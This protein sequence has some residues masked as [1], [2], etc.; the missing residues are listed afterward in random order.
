MNF[1]SMTTSQKWG[2]A[3][4]LAGV[5][6]SHE[7]CQNKGG[8]SLA[9]TP[10]IAA[11]IS[12]SAPGVLRTETP[13]QATATGINV[14]P[15]YFCT[16]PGNA[17][18]PC[19]S[20][21]ICSP[22]SPGT[23][24]TVDNVLVDTGSF[25]LRLF[26]S[27]ISIGLTQLQDGTGRDIAQCAL[28]G[29]GSTWGPV[30]QALVKLGG[31]A[32]SSIPIQVINSSYAT[33][34]TLCSSS[35]PATSPAESGFNGILGIGPFGHDCGT[36][37]G[38]PTYY[39]C[40]GAGTCTSTAPPVLS[41]QVINPVYAQSQDNNGVIVALPGVGLPGATS[42][43]GALIMG[44][45][46]QANNSATGVTA[47]AMNSYMN[48]TTQFNGTSL[49]ESFIDSGTNAFAFPAVPGMNDCGA[50]P[51]WFCP[52][53]PACYTTTLISSTGTTTGISNFRVD[54][55][56][57]IFS[58]GVTIVPTV[59]FGVPSGMSNSFD[60][61]LPFFFG[62]A[63]YVGFKG[64]TATGISITGPYWAY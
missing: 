27:V 30:Q 34:P 9:A 62:R 45:G 31:E 55:A 40:N 54:N 60:W 11:S 44:I 33:M 20:V 4:I 25:G 50:N 8:S 23:C 32:A 38:N 6:F 12:C 56:D 26:S 21:T 63:V 58:Q 57:G 15:I 42:L 28:F 29:I 52:N 61:G 2:L 14:T 53:T 49:T 16:A 1:S 22:T 39:G 36:S 46:T 35:G 17:N 47:Y 37:C 64:R 13:P 7:A 48:F 19:V 3:F 18:I 59:A 51:G 41:K 10:T 43:S 5:M 24:Q